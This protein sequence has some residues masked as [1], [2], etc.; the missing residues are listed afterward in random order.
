ML[1]IALLLHQSPTSQLLSLAS[2]KTTQKNSSLAAVPNKQPSVIPRFCSC[3]R[4]HFIEAA[5]AAFLPICPS[6]AS[7]LHSD[8]YLDLM[9]KIHSPRPDWY[10]EFY[11]SFMDTSMKSYEAE[12]AGYKS[13]LFEKLRGKAKRILEIGIG[14]G[15]NLEYYADNS[16]VQVFGVDP[17]KK[18]EKYARAAAAAVAEAVPLD[19]DSVDAV[20]GTLVLC[21]VKD[22][23]MALKEVKRVLKPGGLFLFV[24]HVAAKDGTILKFWQSVLDPLQQTVADGCHLTRETGKYISTA[25][26]ASLELSMASLYNAP[27]SLISPHIYGVACN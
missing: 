27:C 2:L 5:T 7:S 18:M 6:N 12:I 20:V 9:K 10:E 4:R 25:G 13:Q 8:D 14:T 3:G 26:F 17:N 1:K 11:A 23:N 24:E 15:P 19:D 21:S 16:E 22:V